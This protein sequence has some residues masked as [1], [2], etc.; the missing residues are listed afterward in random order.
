MPQLCGMVLQEQPPPLDRFRTN[1][2]TRFEAVILR[3]LEKDQQRRFQNVGELAA[4]LAEFAPPEAQRSVDRAARLS[5][6]PSSDS[7]SRAQGD[8]ASTTGEQ[9]TQSG[10]GRTSVRGERPRRWPGVLVALVAALGAAGWWWQSH[11]AAVSTAAQPSASVEPMRSASVVQ[12]P[13]AKVAEPFA[14]ASS[15]EPSVT[16]VATPS[17]SAAPVAASAPALRPRPASGP[18]ALPKAT[19]RETAEP[20]APARPAAPVAP[21][22]RPAANPLDGRL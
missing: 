22:P 13:L 15:A 5:G 7:S 17:A 12:A 19:P 20:Q 21:T 11:T 1:T 18:R 4:A 9:F 6:A 8:P 16:P 14:S 2:P 10:F 3:C